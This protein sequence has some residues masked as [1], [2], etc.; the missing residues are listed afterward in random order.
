M[1]RAVDKPRKGAACRTA[2]RN[3]TPIL[4]RASPAPRPAVPARLSGRRPFI[5]SAVSRRAQTDWAE[6]LSYDWSTADNWS[7]GVPRL[8]SVQVLWQRLNGLRDALLATTAL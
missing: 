8:A 5:A 1:A 3:P 2:C 6:T 7:D 4:P